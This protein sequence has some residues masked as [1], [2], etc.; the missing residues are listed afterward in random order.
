M[1][2]SI[3]FIIVIILVIV[4]N[5]FFDFLFG[6]EGLRGLWLFGITVVLPGYIAIFMYILAKESNKKYLFSHFFFAL[7]IYLA[8]YLIPEMRYFDFVKIR[9][10]A[11]GPTKAWMI[12]LVELGTLVLL[13][14][15]IV[16]QIRMLAVRR[17]NKEGGTEE[18]KSK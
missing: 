10:K 12:Y 1:N 7:A 11:D 5:F 18:S 16:G 9:F 6:V 13:L 17:A 3:A 15:L 2:K 14:S 4:I 8:T